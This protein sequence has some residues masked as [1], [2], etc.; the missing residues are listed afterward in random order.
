MSIQYEP[1]IWSDA[2]STGV[3]VIDDQ[4]RILVDLLNVAGQKLSGPYSKETLE[5]IV[6]DLMGYALYHFDTEEELMLQNGYVETDQQQH[7]QEHRSFSTLV[8]SIQHR[9]RQGQHVSVDEL[10]QFLRDWLIHHVLDSDKK[11]GLYL[12]AQG[13]Y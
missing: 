8:S 13:V 5:E 10:L 2:L 7:F 11:L 9:V 12:N 1:V 4:H 3:S 6:R